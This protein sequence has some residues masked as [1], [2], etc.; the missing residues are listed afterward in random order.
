[1]LAN[2]QPTIPN[3]GLS[4]QAEVSPGEPDSFSQG[5][6]FCMD[7]ILFLLE[8][9]KYALLLPLAIIEGPIVSIIAGFLCSINFLSLF[10]AYPLIVFGDL[11]GDAAL[12]TLGHWSEKGWAKKLGDYM[13]LTQEK[14]SQVDKYV[15]SNLFRSVALS[16][17]ILGIGF[18]GLF[19]MGKV[20]IPF[21]RV[22]LFCFF[23]SMLQASFYLITGWFFGAFY[24]QISRYLDYTASLAIA[25]FIAL[26]FFF[27]IRTKVKK[28]ERS[29]RRR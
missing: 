14:M 2:T 27:F 13:G 19:M 15:R 11:L 16:K 8:K 5:L 3:E 21:K 1:M 7:E 25:G 12:Y 23:I 24:K 6:P 17:I 20:K 4:L 18:T 26:I 29:F 9:Y 22:M 10:F 28:Y